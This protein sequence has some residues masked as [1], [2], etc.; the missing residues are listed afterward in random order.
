MTEKKRY[1]FIDQLRGFAIILMVVFHTL[2]NLNLFSHI[3]IPLRNTLWIAFPNIIVTL[4]MLTVGISLALAHYP[5]IRLRPLLLRLLKISLAAILVSLTTWIL[6]P[7]RWVY[8]GIL[9][10]IVVCSLMALPFL[11]FPRIALIGGLLLPFLPL[12]WFQL[13]HPAMDYVPPFPWLSPVLLGIF[14]FHFR[15]GIFLR[16][17]LPSWSSPLAIWGRHALPIYL[18]HQPL[19]Y[20]LLG[21][22]Q[23][24]KTGQPPIP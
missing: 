17:R 10:N 12:P 16:I 20:G 2:Y 18:L 9:H 6:F 11:N 1:L 15:G 21:A 22:I 23:V 5:Q 13:S 14:L 7:H 19:L 24:M 8:F 3:V 4:F